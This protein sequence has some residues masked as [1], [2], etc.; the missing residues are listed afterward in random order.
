MTGPAPGGMLPVMGDPTGERLQIDVAPVALRRLALGLAL[1][2]DGQPATN[3]IID[4][5]Y[6][7]AETSGEEWRGLLVAR[8]ATTRLVGAILVR[9]LAGRVSSLSVPQVMADA[10]PETRRRLVAHALAAADAHNAILAQAL[11]DPED[12]P[13]VAA[14][15][16]EGF[17]HAADLLYLVWRCDVPVASGTVNDLEWIAYRPERHHRLAAVVERTYVNSRDCPQL[18]G[19]RAIDDVLAGYR[20]TGDFAPE[21]WLIAVQNGEDVG[22]LL[23]ADHAADDQWELVYLGVTP[24]ARGRGLGLAITRHAQRLTAESSRARLVLAVDAANT[25]ALGIYMAAGFEPCVRR[26]IYLRHFDKP[27]EM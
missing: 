7:E 8:I 9:H 14:F 5:A 23:L 3:S 19:V 20:A 4:R 17:H 15:A 18:D 21:R 26:A 2:V 6:A 12:T 10:P 25:P 11:V 22:C 16:A 27:R 1:A 13:A 24:E